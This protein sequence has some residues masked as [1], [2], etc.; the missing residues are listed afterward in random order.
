MEREAPLVSIGMPVFNGQRFIRQALDSLLSM[1]YPN[2]ELI[3]SDNAS[4]DGTAEICQDYAARDRR[5]RFYRNAK[6]EGAFGNFAR[7]L[8]LARGN[9]FMWAAHD[10]IWE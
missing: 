7:V 1:D 3:I 10:D 5:I 2:F 4:T 6:N 9:Y 8:A